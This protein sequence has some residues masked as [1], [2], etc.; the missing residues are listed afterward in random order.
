[1]SSSINR[2]AKVCVISGDGTGPDVINATIP[3]LD[4]VQ[5]VVKG[6]QIEYVFAEAGLRGIAKTGQS[7]PDGTKE[8]LKKCDCCLKGPVTTPEQPGSPKSAVV[9]IRSM[10]DLYANLR[11]AKVLPNVPSLRPD[12][13]LLIVRENTEGLYSGIEFMTGPDAAVAVR[14]ITRP[15]CERIARYAFKMAMNRRKQLTYVHKGNVLKVTEAIL[16]DSVLKV[17]K[18]FPE[19]EASEA[20]ID[21]I[22]MNL[23]KNPERYDVI[24]TT[25]LFGDVISDEAAQTVGGL[26]VAP[27]ANIG[28]D[29]GMFEPVHGSAPKYEGLDKVNPVATILAAKMMVEWLGSTE[30]ADRIQ[31]AVESVLR[32]GKVMTYDIA[33]QG[34]TPAKCSE[35]GKRIAQEILNQR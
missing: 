35:M 33:P 29:Y 4:A 18:E 10:F 15:A 31:R 5:D 25:N 3:V 8:I 13:D 6:L 34:V 14:L 20:R 17:A 30:A 16:K 26:G 22:A 1:M 7:L 2:L 32:E 21:A 27:G 11:P 28:E 9:Q 12:I 23:I 24:V 19:V